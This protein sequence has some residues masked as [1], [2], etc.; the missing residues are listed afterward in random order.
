MRL[1][2]TTRRGTP[3]KSPHCTSTPAGPTLLSLQCTVWMHGV[4]YAFGAHDQPCSGVFELVPRTAPG[5]LFRTAIPVGTTTLSPLQVRSI[6]QQLACSYTGISY[7]I[8][9]RNCN[10]F[11]SDLCRLLVDQAPPPWINRLARTALLCNCILPDGV[12]VEVGEVDGEEGERGGGEGRGG[13]R[14]GEEGRRRGREG[15]GTGE[16]RDGGRCGEGRGGGGRRRGPVMVYGVSEEEQRS[17]GRGEGRGGG[18]GGEERGERWWKGKEWAE[19][20]EV[21]Y[22]DTDSEFSD[23]EEDDDGKGGR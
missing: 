13:G 21:G 22:F 2:R 12:R 10:H 18:S 19:G 7:Q 15:G 6:V 23:D 11:T 16:G 20:D 1:A 8:I 3:Q 17:E 14:G 5:F 4:E 9:S